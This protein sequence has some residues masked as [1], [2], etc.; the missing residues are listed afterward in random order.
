MGCICTPTPTCPS[1]KG[2]GSLQVRVAAFSDFKIFQAKLVPS[3]FRPEV[4]RSSLLLKGKCLSSGRR[5]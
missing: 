1:E 4:A 5:L 2:A 3:S